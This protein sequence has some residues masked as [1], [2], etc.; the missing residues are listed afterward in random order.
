MSRSGFLP[1]GFLAADTPPMIILAAWL[2][3]GTT[4]LPII[5]TKGKPITHTVIPTI[6]IIPVVPGMH[7]IIRTLT[8]IIGIRMV[9]IAITGGLDKNIFGLSAPKITI[10]D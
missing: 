6:T 7:T 3:G 10:Q 9:T 8:A 1:V 2:A 5:A 4:H